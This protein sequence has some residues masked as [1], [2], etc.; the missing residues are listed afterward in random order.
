M[1]T[2]AAGW[3]AGSNTSV[4]LAASRSY[5]GVKSL[6]LTATTAGTVSAVTAARVAVTAGTV[7]T[8]YAYF[9]NISVAVGRVAT[10]TVSWYAAVTGGI[11]L[12][13]ST[14]AGVTLPNGTAWATPPP[15]LIATVPAGANF[16]S[17]TVTV[18]GLTTGDTV[19]VD[20]VALGPVPLIADS[21]MTYGDQGVEVD[22]SGWTAVSN[23]TLARDSTASMEG[24]W[25]LAITA[26]ASGD[27]TVQTAAAYTV[28][29]GTEYFAFAWVY[30]P[31]TGQAW[32]TQIDWL[33]ST[34]T[35]ITGASASQ[36]WSG[37][38]AT[39]WTRCGVVAP[40]PAGAVTARLV[41]RP[42]STTSG[43]M[44]LTDQSAFMPAPV[45]PGN[46]VRYAAQSA[47]I[48]A[49]DWSAV[50]G[51]TIARSTVRAW[52]GVASLAVTTTGGDATVRLTPT[53]PVTPRQAYETVPH[54]Y[55]PGI[56]PAQTVDIVYT[57]LDGVG[58]TVSTTSVRWTLGTAAGW[59]APIGS[60]VAPTGAVSAQVS[61]RFNGATAGK[62]FNVDEILVGQGG[63]GVVVDA[64]P[65]LYAARINLQ[66][67][68]TGAY[69][70]WGL[71]RQLPDGT[72]TPVRG[73]DADMTQETISAD[74]DIVEDYEAPLGVPLL[75]RV[76]LWSDTTSYLDATSAPIV[77]PEPPTTEVI[78][79]DP[80][81][82]ARWT[83]AV[84]ETLPDWQR[85]A[86]QGVNQVR[87]R[88]SPIVISDVRMSRTGS[89]TLVTE[90]GEERD[91]LWWLLDTGNTLLIQ[92]PATWHERDMY[93]QV[94]D[95]TEA[96][97]VSTA[98]Y[99]DREWTAALTEVDRPIGGIVGSAD[100]TW[101][102]V[103]DDNT[104]WLAVLASADTW[105]D[106][107]TGV[108]GG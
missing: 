2:S 104:D 54:I 47:E 46:L 42:Q 80:G 29:P 43:L 16:A 88:R 92:W 62:V 66:G 99:A 107:L 19:V 59:Y 52:A 34:G 78:I 108:R 11:A 57:W 51:C 55:S 25:S 3:T 10:V 65:D 21:Q 28:T 22:A 6:G 23:A 60:G 69:M 101:Q 41:L 79:K 30:A 32:I 14:T 15:I 74:L 9:A 27:S 71:W 48:S 81:L 100:R 68:T 58:A 53:V 44:W 70:Y 106:V 72:T 89:V 83:T 24:W 20:G 36:T 8:A 86:R 5:V 13:T 75:Y 38:A 93:V 18:T 98:Q 12:S 64:V 31:T 103:L 37:L 33:D 94:G 45:I 73:S 87:G 76:K 97:A 4:A 7:L 17:V 96:H 35:V 85:S 56:T 90:T 105:L 40:A 1:E 67:L 26:T 63:L 61:L 91:Q 84:V 77:L 50:S 82:P 95:V 102:D 49:A 39:T